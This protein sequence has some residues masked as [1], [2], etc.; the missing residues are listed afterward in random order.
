MC[1]IDVHDFRLQ[2]IPRYFTPF[3]KS[4]TNQNEAQFLFSPT[5]V[6]TNKTEPMYS[7][8]WSEKLLIKIEINE[9]QFTPFFVRRR[10]KDY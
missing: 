7:W 9:A 3:V 5:A 10:M 1:V 4:Y 6:R 8:T 2:I